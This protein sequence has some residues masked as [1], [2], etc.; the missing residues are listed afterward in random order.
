[1]PLVLAASRVWGARRGGLEFGLLRHPLRREL[2]PHL[3]QA[4]NVWLYCVL[5]GGVLAAGG[6]QCSRIL[7]SLNAAQFDV[8]FA[9]F[10]AGLVVLAALA[11]VPRR[12][13]Y[14]ATNVVVALLSGFLVSSSCRYPTRP[15][16]RSCST[17]P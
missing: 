11:L 7:F 5:L 9:T 17:R 14:A 6:L 12:R 3:V 4:L 1:M 13:V 8:V 10:A 16:T 15:P 2:R